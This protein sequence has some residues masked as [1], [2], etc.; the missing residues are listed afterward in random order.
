MS[1]CKKPPEGKILNPATNR[2]VKIDGRI[3][4]KIIA[5]MQQQEQKQ[6]RKHNILE[7]LS[8]RCN[9]DA[10]PIS[11]DKFEDLDEH[12]LDM[13]VE[14]GQ[15]PKKNCYMLENIY[16]VYKTAIESKK[17]PK[18]P[19]N[20]QHILTK[21]EIEDINTKKKQRD[22]SYQPPVYNEPQLYPPGYTLIIVPDLFYVQYF[23]I[24][25]YYNE[26]VRYDLGIVPGWVDI[27]NTGSTDY[28]S[29]VLLANI[30]E[31][32]DRQL[33]LKYAKRPNFMRR[34]FMDFADTWHVTFIELCDQVK[35]ALEEN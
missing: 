3:G 5:S 29:G 21:K 27:E 34:T 6:N 2:Y 17:D 33:M 7:Q 24:Q 10:D 20:P 16:N 22:P 25:V 14:I 31:L 4:K 19:M 30:R 11:F 12:E 26:R 13:L 9:N 15:G 35:N 8:A 28:T 23:H 1:Q 18:D 32:W